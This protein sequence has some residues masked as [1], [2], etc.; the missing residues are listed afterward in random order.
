MSRRTGRAPTAQLK[1]TPVRLATRA[2]KL[3][4]TQSE[5]VAAAL[6]E[7]GLDV[8]LVH[9]TTHGDVVSTPL[10]KMGGI[11][12]FASAIRTDLLE[13]RCDIAVHS[14]KDLPTGQPLGLTVAAVPARE[15][16][17]D[18]LVARDRLKLADLPAGSKVGTGSPRR[19][20]QL[21]AARPDLEIV[22]IRGNVDTRV[23]RVRGFGG[24]ED[25]DAVI[26]AASGLSRLGRG[27]DITEVLD[28]DVML[29]A[30][31]QGALAVECRTADSRHGALAKGL[32]AIDDLPSRLCATAERAVLAG[33]EAGCAAPV[34]C[35]AKVESGLLDLHA[36]V[37]SVDGTK[38]VRVQAGLEL[39]SAA[40]AKAD[41]IATLA[42]A[43]HTL[44]IQ[45]AE[46]LLAQGAA[47]IADLH[48]SK[49]RR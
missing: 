5:L 9:V 26:V 23:G 10:S 8:E 36:V 40:P 39:P 38:S 13:G 46:D 35:L 34:G 21:R 18:A 41:D 48:V 42:G 22:D 4:T 24:R 20:A 16:P 14:F 44:G 30:P 43:A 31:A 28:A 7:H 19:A 6:D 25:L 27:S 17:H 45:V 33:L 2:S 12:V 11:G 49:A 15:D 37:V 29:P 47:E 32:A 1:R 3:A